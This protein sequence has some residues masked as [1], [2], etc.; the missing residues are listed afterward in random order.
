MMIYEQLKKRRIPDFDLTAHR[1][2]LSGK[3]FALRYR[4]SMKTFDELLELLREHLTT[5]S[6][7]HAKS[8]RGIHTL[9]DDQAKLAVLETE[10]RSRSR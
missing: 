6:T 9:I 10:F 2:R 7:I 1:E 3:Q 8:S 5:K 4:L